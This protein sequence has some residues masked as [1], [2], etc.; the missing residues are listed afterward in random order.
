MQEENVV[1][2]YH[3]RTINKSRFADPHLA[4]ALQGRFLVNPSK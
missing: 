2:Q 1:E 4:T 3:A